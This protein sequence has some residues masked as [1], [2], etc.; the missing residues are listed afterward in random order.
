MNTK[1]F[2]DPW[3]LGQAPQG[4]HTTHTPRSLLPTGDALST[5]SA[6]CGDHMASRSLRDQQVWVLVIS[7][8]LKA[9]W[10]ARD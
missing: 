8:L 1:G 2:L 9:G 3:R 7:A 6:V 5:D 4:C 10:F